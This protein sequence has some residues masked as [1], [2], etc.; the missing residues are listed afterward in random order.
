MRAAFHMMLSSPSAL[1]DLGSTTLPPCSP[2]LTCPYATMP[3]LLVPS[4][5][6]GLFPLFGTIPPVFLGKLT[7]C[8]PWHTSPHLF[9]AP[10]SHPSSQTRFL[11]FFSTPSPQPRSFSLC[12]FSPPIYA[13]CRHQGQNTSSSR[14]CVKELNV[15]ELMSLCL[16]QQ[17]WRRALAETS[18]WDPA[19]TDQSTLCAEETSS[20]CQTCKPLP[21]VC[22][23]QFSKGL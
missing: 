12:C 13:T 9:P 16:C 20:S 18:C 5:P 22:K 6:V 7:L 21:G 4:P 1:R 3:A 19:A 8:F 11:T 23:L 17:A 14:F 2:L 15:A 10:V